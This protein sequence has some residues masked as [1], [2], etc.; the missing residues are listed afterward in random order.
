MLAQTISQDIL[1]PVAT[2]D[3]QAFVACIDPAQQ[4][5]IASLGQAATNIIEGYLGDYVQQRSV[6]WI[7]SRGENEKTQAFFAS[8]LSSRSFISYGFNA[9]AGQWIDFPTAAQS[10]ENVTLGV[11]GMSEWPLV[12]GQDYAVD[13]M[14]NPARMSITYNLAV[15][16][17]FTNFSH[18]E[19]DYTGGIAPAGSCPQTIQL[20]IKILTKNLFDNRGTSGTVLFDDA[21]KGLLVNYRRI[22]FGGAG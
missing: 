13:L 15:Q 20:A 5:L 8:W 18:L 1:C 3:L 9:V 10:V 12:I 11:W 14:T 7:L 17:Y 4:P 6:R 2:S 22:G 21:I 16:D 19:V